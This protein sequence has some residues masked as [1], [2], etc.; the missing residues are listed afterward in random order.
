MI[1]LAFVDD[2]IS[3]LYS[4]TTSGGSYG[5]NSQMQFSTDSSGGQHTITVSLAAIAQNIAKGGIIN[6]HVS[7]PCALNWDAY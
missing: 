7:F 4:S 2:R 6:A 5:P 3:Q 1:T